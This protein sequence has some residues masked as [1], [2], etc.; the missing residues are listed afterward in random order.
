MSALEKGPQRGRNATGQEDHNF[1]N[2]YFNRATPNFDVGPWSNAWLFILLFSQN[3]ADEC[4]SVQP[5][6]SRR[7]LTTKCAQPEV[8][9]A[10]LLFVVL[11]VLP[12]MGQV[13][14]N[15][16]HDQNQQHQKHNF[17]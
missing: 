3:N 12:P 14:S 10:S 4:I 11:L 5:P 8:L 17:Q 1:Q 15:C 13:H 7:G 2:K 6:Y 9:I 16:R